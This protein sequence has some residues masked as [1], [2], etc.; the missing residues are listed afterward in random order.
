MMCSCCV[1]LRFLFGGVVVS[2]LLFCFSCVCEFVCLFLARLCLYAWDCD[3]RLVVCC[4]CFL[5]VLFVVLLCVVMICFCCLFAYF[6]CLFACVC[7]YIVC[8][9]VLA[10]VCLL[11]RG[12]LFVWLFL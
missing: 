10:F 12:Y 1:W 6:V 4:V 7:L 11:V 2:V 5:A 8:L 3:L 9:G